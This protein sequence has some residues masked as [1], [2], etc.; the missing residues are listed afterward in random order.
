MPAKK[1]VIVGGGS[2]YIPGFVKAML[3]DKDKFVDWNVT[4]YDINIENLNLIAGLSEKMARST[5]ARIT[6]RAETELARALEGA[7][8]VLT[9]FRAGGFEMRLFD[10]KTPLDF[11][12][13]GHE[14]VGPGGFFYALRTI[15]VVKNLVQ[16]IERV[17]PGVTILNYTN[18][19]NIVTE[20]VCLHSK[21]NIFGMCDQPI[22]DCSVFARWLGYPN[23]KIDFAS[24]GLN[25]AN[26]GVELKLDGKDAM[27]LIRKEAQRI[28]KE[29]E[30]SGEERLQVELAEVSGLI[31]SKYNQY[32][33]YPARTVERA[34]KEGRVRTEVI[35]EGMP[36]IFEHLKE[37]AQLENPVVVKHR[38]SDDFGDFAIDILAALSGGGK[39]VEPLN[40][41]NNGLIDD[42]P[43][44]LVVEVP[45]EIDKDRVTPR[46]MG[47]L[48]EQFAGLLYALG[49]FQRLTARAAWSGDYHD[50]VLALA[51]N[52]L[53]G[54]LDL[55]TGIYD[56]MTLECVDYLPERLM[57]A[58]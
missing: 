23:A 43:E 4:L 11:G 20:A 35:L 3:A 16:Q 6:Y 34:K 22:H 31:P 8:Y 50:A 56:R 40:V 47:L 44:G 9:S 19:T 53:I 45:C 7:D 32:Y 55:A 18:P 48:P 15:P 13:I 28:L 27:P 17:C 5:G 54:D 41:V 29:K 2:A 52:P 57:P 1:L 38:G 26:W 39:T 30:L 36:E 46:P 58:K 10:E 12:V 21:V 49:N 37:Q 42:L 33:Y 25:H 14:T 51:A 24:V